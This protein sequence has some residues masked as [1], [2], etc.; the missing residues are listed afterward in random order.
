L[1][2]VPS[3]S[4]EVDARPHARAF[5]LVLVALFVASLVA[6][7]ID[8]LVRPPEARSVRRENRLAG[9]FPAHVTGFTTLSRFPSDFQR[10]FDDRL[11]LRD[12]MLK[13]Y[14]AV[15]L[16]VFPTEPS[17]TMV[18]GYDGWLFFG[19]DNSVNVHRGLAPFAE[20]DLETWRRALEL[21]RDWLKARG[22]EYVF[23]I[24]PNKQSIYPELWPA[25]LNAIGPT[26]MDQLARWMQQHSDLT[27]VDLRPAVTAEKAHDT[28]DDFTYSELGSHWTSRGAM[29]GWNAIVVAMQSKFPTVSP[30]DRAE[31]TRREL[32]EREGD[33]FQW[34]MYVPELLHQRVYTLERIPT[35][36]ARAPSPSDGDRTSVVVVHDSFGPWLLPFV[37]HSN[38]DLVSSMWQND[39]PKD[40]LLVHSPDVVV[41]IYTERMLVW[42]LMPLVPDVDRVTAAEFQSSAPLWGPLDLNTRPAG[43]ETQGRISI[44]AR[45]GTL[46]IEVGGRDGL[47]TLPPVD[48]PAESE[49]TMHVD[50]TAPLPS[51][52]SLYYP[53]RGETT[54][55]RHRVAYVS[56]QGGRNDIYV[57]IRAQDVA[58]PLGLRFGTASGT[59]TLHAIEARAAR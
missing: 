42:G 31:Y 23:A 37:P 1:I 38:V 29:A 30:I 13:G 43:V 46:R 28:R 10:W 49:L 34:Q 44:D 12:V 26:R 19:S 52:M 35:D 20:A 16:F 14:Q 56:V 18:I 11:G 32:D 50:V 21:R 8:H 7:S 6:P 22:V 4:C 41:Q 3:G 24:A 53:R 9:D 47:I 25:S 40:A 2:R 39:F 55:S 17:P 59:Y 58:G 15:R 36:P 33:S 5:D 48:V 57:R 45:G 27:F 51:M 54:F